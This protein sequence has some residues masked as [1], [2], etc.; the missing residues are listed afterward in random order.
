[1]NLPNFFKLKRSHK[2]IHACICGVDSKRMSRLSIKDH[3]VQI[4]L[5]ICSI[6]FS[7]GILYMQK[8]PDYH[9]SR[10]D[11]AAILLPFIIIGIHIYRITSIAREQLK[12][13]H[14]FKCAVRYA[15]YQS[16]Y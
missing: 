14:T 10:Y 3:Y 6:A 8:N 7:V 5:L 13:H 4:I 1:M 9:K 2:H 12:K 15:F 16:L 11:L